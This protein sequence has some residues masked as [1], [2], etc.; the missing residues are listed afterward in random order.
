MMEMRTLGRDAGNV[1]HIRGE[2]E[3]IEPEPPA[4]TGTDSP[5]L[6]YTGAGGGPVCV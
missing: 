5:G 3:Q 1:L 2:A 4:W 6:E